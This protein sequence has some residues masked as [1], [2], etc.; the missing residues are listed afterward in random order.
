VP[1]LN[2]GTYTVTMGNHPS[3]RASATIRVVPSGAR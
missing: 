2:L 3:F 1:L